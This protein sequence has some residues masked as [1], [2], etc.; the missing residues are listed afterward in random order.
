MDVPAPPD[1]APGRR[2]R[3]LVLAAIVLV[4]GVPIT[5][6]TWLSERN[7]DREAKALAEDVRIA[8]RLVDDIG[9]LGPDGGPRRLAEAVG[10]GDELAGAAFGADEISAAYEVRWGFAARCVH[11]LLRADEVRTDVTDSTTCVPRDL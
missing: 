4:V 6:W 5:G 3:G 10:H 9:A 1:D 7:A 8:A 2:H 11:L